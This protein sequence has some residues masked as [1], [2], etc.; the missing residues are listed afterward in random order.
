MYYSEIR[1]EVDKTLENNNYY[2][3]IIL[4]FPEIIK[5]IARFL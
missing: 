3:Y 4:I 1:S 5:K 2:K